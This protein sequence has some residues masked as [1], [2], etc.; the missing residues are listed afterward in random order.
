MMVAD[1]RKARQVLVEMMDLIGCC[2]SLLLCWVKIRHEHLIR[3]D[4]SLKLRCKRDGVINLIVSNCLPKRNVECNE[5]ARSS[6]SQVF[7]NL[8]VMSVWLDEENDNLLLP[9]RQ[10]RFAQWKRRNEDGSSRWS[11]LKTWWL[12]M[13]LAMNETTCFFH[14]WTESCSPFWQTEL[15]RTNLNGLIR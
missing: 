4:V 2:H 14:S 6:I 7:L 1:M 11:S 9:R 3:W 5:P 12:I 15:N 10:R 13:R 8:R